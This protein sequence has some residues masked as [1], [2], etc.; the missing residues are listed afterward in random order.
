MSRLLTIDQAADQLGTGPRFIRRLVHER[1]IA[2]HKV[3]RHVRIDEADLINFVAAG[4][5]EAID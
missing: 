3:G 4:R 5:I 2:F 1:R